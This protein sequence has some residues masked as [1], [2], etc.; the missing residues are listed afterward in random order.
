MTRGRLG[1]P[2]RAEAERG[3]RPARHRPSPFGLNL[4]YPTR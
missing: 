4:K 2:A 1:R 3:R